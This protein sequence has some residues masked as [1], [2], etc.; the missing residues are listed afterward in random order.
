MKEE[1]AQVVVKRF[2]YLF[3]SRR[4]FQVYGD[5]MLAW[6]HS[7]KNREKRRMAFQTYFR[8]SRRVGRERLW[9]KLEACVEIGVRSWFP[10]IAYM[11]FYEEED[12][13]TRRQAIEMFGNR[14]HLWWVY[15]D[16]A[17]MLE[18]AY[19]KTS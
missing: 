15:R 11:G 14:V 4:M 17:L 13:T 8:C 7:E 3:S 19:L 6:Q 12:R 1:C 10:D 16:G 9:Q 5:D 2:V 18:E